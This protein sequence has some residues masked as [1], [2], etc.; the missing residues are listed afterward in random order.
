ME[1]TR[2]AKLISWFQHIVFENIIIVNLFYSQ[3]IIEES[4]ILNDVLLSER[5]YLSH[6]V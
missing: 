4:T 3:N 1:L 5:Q 6:F 2:K